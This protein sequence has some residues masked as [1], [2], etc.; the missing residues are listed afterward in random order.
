MQR[1]RIVARIDSDG[2]RGQHRSRIKPRLH[3]HD[4]DARDRIS[5]QERSLNGRRAA[6]ARQQR[7]VNIDAAILGKLEHGGRQNQAVGDHD[8]GIDRRGSQHFDRP[9]RSKA[10]G[11]MHGQSEPER[12]A[13]DGTQVQRLTPARRSVRLGENG[14]YGMQRGEPLQRR[15]REVRRA[16]E[17]QPQGRSGAQGSKSRRVRA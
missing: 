17:A 14:G 16:G 7:S 5:R 3:A 1:F 8:Q 15:N 6:P 2:A 12:A 11:L 10:R 9:G 4:G 13:L